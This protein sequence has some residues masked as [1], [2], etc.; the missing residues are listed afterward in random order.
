MGEDMR[1]QEKELLEYIKSKLLKEKNTTL[2]ASTKLFEEGFIDSM[3]ILDLIGFVEKKIGK[4]LNSEEI[5]MK[6][7]KSVST[8]INAFLNEKK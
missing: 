1:K 4:K 3:N 2:T 6:N 8:I 7:F 5:I